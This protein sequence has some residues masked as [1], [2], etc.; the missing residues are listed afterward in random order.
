MKRVYKKLVFLLA[1]IMLETGI[2]LALCSCTS[3][4]SPDIS[5]IDDVE[6]FCQDH[7]ISNLEASGIQYYQTDTNSVFVADQ[8]N[9]D[10]SLYV[11]SNIVASVDQNG[12]LVVRVI[13]SVAIS[14]ND[15]S[16]SYAVLIT[17]TTTISKIEI[18]QVDKTK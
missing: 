6:K 2:L 16:G 11:H 15:I 3:V 10:K 1:A 8:R 17:S 18:E 4:Q 14:E 7:N 9:S 5:Y 13:D 12:K